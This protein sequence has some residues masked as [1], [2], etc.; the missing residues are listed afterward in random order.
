LH[1]F[2]KDDLFYFA[3][4]IG[5]MLLLSVLF[6]SLIIF[7][8]YK[9]LKSYFLQKKIS[10]LKTDLINNVS[11]EFKTPI[12]SIG[13]AGEMIKSFNDFRTE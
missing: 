6:L 9:T 13:L 1:L 2:I 5:I 7:V 4:K 11:H 10:E 3:K 12:A 8:F